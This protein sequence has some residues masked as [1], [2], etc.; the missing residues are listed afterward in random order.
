MKNDNFFKHDATAAD[1][2]KILLL[3]EREGLKGYGA[4]WILIEALRKQDDLCSSFSVLRSL[5]IRSR[6]RLPHCFSRLPAM[7]PVTLPN[8]ENNS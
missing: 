1:D 8:M 2:E 3:I 4:Y 6:V 5:A 7:L